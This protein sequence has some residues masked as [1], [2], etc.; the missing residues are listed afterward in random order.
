MDT[1][2]V[3]QTLQSDIPCPVCARKT[4][5]LK[6]SSEPG[7]SQDRYV[8]TC[9]AC[10]HPFEVERNGPEPSAGRP[11]ER[12]PDG[13]LEPVLRRRAA[14]NRFEVAWVCRHCEGAGAALLMA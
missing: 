5:D 4:F 12:C 10:G 6:P 14:S 2:T 1:L 8:A 7:R 11:C 13:V 9:T 3:T